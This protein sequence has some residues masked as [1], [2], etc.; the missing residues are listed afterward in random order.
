MKELKQIIMNKCGFKY[1]EITNIFATKNYIVFSVKN[2]IFI[3]C[4][5]LKKITNI[6]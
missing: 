6:I 3:F 1:R 4:K 2:N 5:E